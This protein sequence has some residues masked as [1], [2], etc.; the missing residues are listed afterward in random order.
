MTEILRP[1]APDVADL[2]DSAPCGL[3]TARED[4]TILTTN[5]TFAEW[6]G[7]DAPSLIGARFPDL[8]DAGSRI[9]FETRL[10]PVLRL[11]GRV[12]GI[13]LT[14]RGRV[15]GGLPVLAT[16]TLDIAR[17]GGSPVARYALFDATERRNYERELLESQRA[18]ENSARTLR[19]LQDSAGSFAKSANEHDFAR[20]V[21]GTFRQA[22]RASD[23]VV[24]TCDANDVLA[25]SSG[26]TRV[27][28]GSVLH[29]VLDGEA[30]TTVPPSA[31]PAA[32][33]EMTDDRRF[34]AVTITP[35]RSE[36]SRLGVVVCAYRR[37][38]ELDVD[39]LALHAALSN[40]AGVALSRGRLQTELTRM[41]HHD[42]LTGL[43]NR[44]VLRSSLARLWM[45][46][47]AERAP[48]AVL[49]MDLDGFKGINDGLGH[50]AGDAV[51]QEVAG[52][53]RSSVRAND[54]VG[55]YGGDEFVVVCEDTGRE[56]AAMIADRV[57]LCIAA[58]MPDV[59]PRYPLS[60]SIGVVVARSDSTLTAD[61]LL[62]L[63]DSAMYRSKDAGKN[64]VTVI[65]A[66]PAALRSVRRSGADR[67]RPSKVGD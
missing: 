4:G 10:A 37:R 63:A 52:R 13:S 47:T 58:P 16:V 6:S 46:P 5:R 55:R 40:Q 61:E 17:D 15:P 38:P 56:Q 14:L 50:G 57:A 23:V 53:I 25:D 41:A 39:A 51:L 48:L 42:Q 8:L 12:R 34:E 64:S 44:G 29:E 66:T 21:A 20:V 26:R 36:G 28:P 65:E 33:G 19:L 45:R 67:Q 62:G 27:Q 43:A 59:D 24:L 1:E 32:L 9:F 22:F 54:L 60:A 11:E 30:T 2:V 18:A 7:L 31:M 35:L 3:F 49:F